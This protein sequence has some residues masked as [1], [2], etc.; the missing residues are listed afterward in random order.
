M[1]LSELVMANRR[2]WEYAIEFEGK[3]KVKIGATPTATATTMAASTS[4]Q[5]IFVMDLFAYSITL[6]LHQSMEI[7]IISR[8]F[9]A[10]LGTRMANAADYDEYLNLAMSLSEA[11]NQTLGARKSWFGGAIK[12]GHYCADK[13]CKTKSIVTADGI[14]WCIE[15]MGER[16]NA[17]IA[18][19]SECSLKKDDI[20]AMMGIRQCEKHCNDQYMNIV[21]VTNTE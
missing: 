19:L 17:A 11:Y 9:G 10:E 12:V 3:M 1:T 18:C 14:H 2:I 7:G 15:E 13:D 6:F 21:P 4:K 16:M 20:N 5:Q 8:D